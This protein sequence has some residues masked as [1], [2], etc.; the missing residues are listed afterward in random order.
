MYNEHVRTKSD[1]LSVARIAVANKSSIMCLVKGSG[2]QAG[3]R[4]IS[5]LS[6]QSEPDDLAITGECSSDNLTVPATFACIDD[7]AEWVWSNRKAIN[8]YTKD[9]SGNLRT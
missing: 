3:S 5:K 9:Y 4:F 6:I 2:K 8:A 7:L 1:A